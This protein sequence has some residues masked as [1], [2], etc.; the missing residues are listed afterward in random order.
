MIFQDKLDRALKF[1]KEKKE[2]RRENLMSDKLPLEKNDG[3][4]MAIA[5]ALTFLPIFAVLLII[6]LL[7][8]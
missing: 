7:C 1:Q 8:L 3:L 4:A 5:A 6:A 2:E